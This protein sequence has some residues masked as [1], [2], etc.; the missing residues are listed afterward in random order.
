MGKKVN[1]QQFAA[2]FKPQEYLVG[3]LSQLTVGAASLS[4]VQSNNSS[5]IDMTLDPNI[6]I[7]DLTKERIRITYNGVQL[8]KHERP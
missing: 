7:F 4:V 2:F 8:R 3:Q 5:I 1:A 6:E